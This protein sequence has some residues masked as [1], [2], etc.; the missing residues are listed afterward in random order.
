MGCMANHVASLAVWIGG[1]WRRSTVIRL[2]RVRTKHGL[3]GAEVAIRPP[4][5]HGHQPT[6][7]GPTHRHKQAKWIGDAGQAGRWTTLHA[8]A[9]PA[10][11]LFPRAPALLCR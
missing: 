2:G 10:A 4:E 11:H 6:A 9:N 1:R 5:R 7:V 8:H 3:Y